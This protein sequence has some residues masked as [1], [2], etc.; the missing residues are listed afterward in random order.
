[1]TITTIIILVALTAVSL[2][3][4]TLDVFMILCMREDFLGFLFGRI[5]LG[6]ISTVFNISATCLVIK[7]WIHIL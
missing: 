3:V 2:I 7:T 4:G 6:I 1:M 5:P